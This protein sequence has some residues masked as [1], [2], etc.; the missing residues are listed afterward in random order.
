MEERNIA[1]FLGV[2]DANCFFRD[3]WNFLPA[4]IKKQ[5]ELQC[6]D[7]YQPLPF[8]SD[9]SKLLSNGAMISRVTEEYILPGYYQ[10]KDGRKNEVFML[11][12]PDHFILL[13]GLFRSLVSDVLE[14]SLR[15]STINKKSKN[16][17]QSGEASRARGV[18]RTFGRF[19][20]LAI[21]KVQTKNIQ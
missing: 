15:T 17:E 16:L 10:Y 7:L 11:T 18:S 13:T 12:A 4:T 6:F 1:T 5:D 8:G 21:T 9:K 3:Q 20:T 14:I 2:Q 19:F